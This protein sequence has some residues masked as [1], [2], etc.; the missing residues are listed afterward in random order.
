MLKKRT[1]V[2]ISYAVSP[3]RNLYNQYNYPMSH[4]NISSPK[5]LIHLVCRRIFIVTYRSLVDNITPRCVFVLGGRVC[6]KLGLMFQA[7][8]HFVRSMVQ[9]LLYAVCLDL[10]LLLAMAFARAVFL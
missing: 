9:C 6:R 7:Y 8:I 3:A 1:S 2:N 4:L 5:S 10:Y